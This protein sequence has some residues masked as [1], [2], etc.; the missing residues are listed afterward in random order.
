MLLT[1]EQIGII[2]SHLSKKGIKCPAC[3]AGFSKLKVQDS[4]I[5]SFQW[6]PFRVTDF[7][8][9]QGPGGRIFIV[10]CKECEYILPFN[11]EVLFDADGPLDFPLSQ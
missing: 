5:Q 2:Q 8:M 9:V 4:I 1:V 3:N 6:R 10:V 11:A 7:P